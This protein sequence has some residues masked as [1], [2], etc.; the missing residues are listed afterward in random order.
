KSNGGVMFPEAAKE[1]PVHSITS[2]PAGGVI[3]ARHFGSRFGFEK[4]V[5]LDMGGTSCDLSVLTDGE[6]NYTTSFELEFG[7]PINVPMI[8]IATIGAGGGSIAWVDEGN[9]LNVGPRSAG[10]QPGPAC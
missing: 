9:L 5:S 3:S 7:L 10:A 8:D 4:M 1:N 6:Q 2:G